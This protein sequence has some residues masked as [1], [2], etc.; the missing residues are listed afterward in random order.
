MG[1]GV[2][3][4]VCGEAAL[5]ARGV[6]PLK[7]SEGAEEGAL[8]SAADDDRDWAAEADGAPCAGEGAGMTRC[9]GPDWAGP[10]EEGLDA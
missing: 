1:R 4:G 3:A 5:L 2:V 7:A 8:A 6:T 10:R 9:E